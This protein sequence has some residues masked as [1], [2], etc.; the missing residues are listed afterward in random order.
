M[1]ALA[2]STLLITACGPTL[3][4]VQNPCPTIG[5]YQPLRRGGRRGAPERTFFVD[6]QPASSFDTERL[7]LDSPP[8]HD[9]AAHARRWLGG[10]LGFV[11]VIA[12]SVITGFALLAADGDKRGARSAA[13]GGV[14]AVGL[15]VGAIGVAVSVHE[16]RAHLESAVR[17]CAD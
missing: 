10:T 2:L 9:E 15:G 13:G 6:G 11:G 17:Q 8:A 3:A 16:R 7:L 12:A 5:W 14:A 4:E 1:R